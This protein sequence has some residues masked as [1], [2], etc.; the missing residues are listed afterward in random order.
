MSVSHFLSIVVVFAYLIWWCSPTLQITSYTKCQIIKRHAT[1][2]FEVVDLTA[3]SGPSE[4]LEPELFYHWVPG[5]CKLLTYANWKLKFSIRCDFKNVS[6]WSN[7]RAKW[8]ESEVWP[9]VTFLFCLVYYGIYFYQTYFASYFRY[10]TVHALSI[11]PGFQCNYVQIYHL[12]SSLIRL[13]KLFFFHMKCSKTIHLTRGPV[14]LWIIKGT[15]N[16]QHS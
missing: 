1:P 12:T 7:Q 16:T 3:E 6:L 13:S 15:Y 2:Q 11:N 14:W 4:A 9:R 10:G 5:F 8:V